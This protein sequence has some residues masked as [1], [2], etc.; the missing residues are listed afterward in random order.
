MR[1]FLPN[2]KS[3]TVYSFSPAGAPLGFATVIP[4]TE[5]NNN[6]LSAA[7]AQRL[8]ERAA[9]AAPWLLTDIGA[10]GSG[11][12]FE[13][14]E[15]SD[16]VQLGGRVD[17]TFVY[18]RVHERISS[19]SSSLASTDSQASSG[20][21]AMAAAEDG[22]YRLRLSIAGDKFVGLSHYVKVPQQFSYV[23][24]LYTPEYIYIY[25]FLF[26]FFCFGNVC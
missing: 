16:T 2:D 3:E 15:G 6:T 22:R 1:H 10:K 13:L 5:H 25:L 21:S 9:A 24:I 18:E 4:E 20:D 23:W 7:E 12:A 14:I 19:S 26:F 11:K 8:A 17:H